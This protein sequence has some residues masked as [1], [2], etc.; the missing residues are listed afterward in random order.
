MGQAKQRGTFDQ[1]KEAAIQRDQ[2]AAEAR[3]IAKEETQAQERA[4][5][6]RTSAVTYGQ[7]MGGSIR[8]ASLM[9]ALAI[10]SHSGRTR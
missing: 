2:T 5:V 7:G 9:A 3:R 1:R 6:P 10:I 8:A 4:R